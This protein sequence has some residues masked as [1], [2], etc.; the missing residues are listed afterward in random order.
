MNTLEK[1]KKILREQNFDFFISQESKNLVELRI[2]V[3]DETKNNSGK[4]SEN[5]I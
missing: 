4:T 3:E 2:F 1:L 5:I